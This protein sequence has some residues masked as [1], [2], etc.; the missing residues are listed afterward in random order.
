MR[1]K[2]ILVVICFCSAINLSLT[3]AQTIE[4]RISNLTTLSG[5]EFADSVDSISKDIYKMP[6]SKAK[7]AIAKFLDV[8]KPLNYE[9]YLKGRGLELFF[10]NFGQIQK[11]DSIYYL[12][13]KNNIK[14]MMGWAAARK[15]EYYKKWN[16]YDSS[17]I[18]IL[19]ANDIFKE[20]EDE[21]KLVSVKNTLADLYF[22]A[23]DYSTAEQM[24]LEIQQIKGNMDQWNTWRKQTITNNLALID[25]KRGNYK[26]AISKF[27]ISLN[28]V[29]LRNFGRNDSISQAYIYS[30]LANLYL[31][32]NE[33]NSF[34]TSYQKGILPAVRYKQNKFAAKLY[35]GKSKYFAQNREIDSTLKYISLAEKMNNDSRVSI[36]FLT[37]ITAFKANFYKDVGDFK[38]SSIYFSKAMVLYDSLTNL[39]MNQQHLQLLAKT[40]Y[41][42]L[43][44]EYLE[45]E[46]ELRFVIYSIILVIIIIIIITILYLK[47][48]KAYK[49]LVRKNQEIE[50]IYDSDAIK[51]NTQKAA[52]FSNIEMEM[53]VNLLDTK[54]NEEKYY[55]NKDVSLDKMAEVLGTNRT[56]LSKSINQI[57]GENFSTYINKLRTK[58]VLRIIKKGDFENLSMEGIADECGF[59]SRSAFFTAFKQ[60]TGVTPSFFINNL[61]TK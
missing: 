3:K 11:L 14:S 48:Q 41:D 25:L 1:K 24:Y 36:E 34:L 28:E 46:N 21:H 50:S 54:M 49:T 20:L 2:L 44:K 29:L 60:Y 52:N 55:L 31:I 7:R 5:K 17:M 43:K 27:N 53:I 61:N 10:D 38:N 19:E 47:L 42:N 33:K 6:K 26:E 4:E 59:K 22:A 32:I 9:S 45:K 16:Q 40:N 30:E 37:E 15:G 58:E 51:S 39:Q 23:K 18:F 56:Y 12:A 8:T 35:F 57:K 13:K